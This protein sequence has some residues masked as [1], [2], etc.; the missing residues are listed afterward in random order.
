MKTDAL[1][2]TEHDTQYGQLTLIASHEGLRAV[3]WPDADHEVQIDGETEDDPGHHLLVEAVAQLDAYAAGAR[4][5]FDVPLDL[6]GTEFQL[7][8]WRQLTEI[9]YGHTSTYGDVARDIGR[10][11]AVRAVGGAIGRNP[12]PI[13]VPCHRVIGSDGSLTGFGGGLDL[14]RSLLDHERYVSL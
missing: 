8:V 4:R 7:T 9:P 1:A 13:I 2:R 10:P 3:T 6:R 5:N 12:V 14:K 11:R